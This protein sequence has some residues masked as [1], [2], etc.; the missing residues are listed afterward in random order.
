MPVMP[1]RK[2][3]KIDKGCFV[4]ISMELKYHMMQTCDSPF[5]LISF[6]EQPRGWV[7]ATIEYE[8]ESKHIW[9][10]SAYAYFIW[11]YST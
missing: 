3:W 5:L 4:K 2:I 6:L 7:V 11:R 9:L 8:L 1:P 10:S